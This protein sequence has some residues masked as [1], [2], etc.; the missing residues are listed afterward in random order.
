MRAI[1]ETKVEALRVQLEELRHLHN[2]LAQ[3][4]NFC[5]GEKAERCPIIAHFEENEGPAAAR[6]KT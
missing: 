6:I 3:L 5:R 2:E 1:T 4:L